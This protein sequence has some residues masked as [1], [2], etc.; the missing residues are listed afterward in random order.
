M[1]IT[2]DSRAGEPLYLQIRNQIVAG[3]ATGELE[4]GASLP[5]VRALA[6]DLGINLH[7]VNKAYAVLRDEG[8]VRIRGR[9]G[10]SIA[11]PLDDD[12]AASEVAQSQMEES[13]FR[14]ALA[15]R[16][17]GGAAEDFLEA[18]ADQ[19]E[20]VYAAAAAD[21]DASGDKAGSEAGRE[22]GEALPSGDRGV[23][24]VARKK[25]C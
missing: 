21:A 11:D 10:A 1:L 5:S 24:P 6:S 2:V 8:Y 18:A 13:L 14:L 7:T 4:P 16:A 9:A 22:A 23:R 19:V 17:R 25:G 15:F 3:I 12:A 20:R